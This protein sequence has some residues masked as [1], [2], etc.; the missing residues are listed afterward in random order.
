MRKTTILITL[1]FLLTCVISC[2][3]DTNSNNSIPTNAL[4]GVWNF[5]GIQSNNFVNTSNGVNT[6]IFT[7]D[8][9]TSGN[10]GTLNI[11]GDRLTCSDIG[12]TAITPSLIVSYQNGT[13]NDTLQNTF[14]TNIISSINSNLT[15]E[16]IGTDSIHFIGSGFP[17]SLGNNN[18]VVTGAKFSIT[19]DILTF[20]SYVFINKMSG[21]PTAQYQT[22]TLVST[23][24]KQ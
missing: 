9:T 6:T 10:S 15:Y 4:V 5:E 11:S 2:K 12:Y 7:S 20:T 1:A 18:P 19:G 14:N 8:Y 16:I 22:D 21:P 24:R 23:L 3:K 17:D 13:P